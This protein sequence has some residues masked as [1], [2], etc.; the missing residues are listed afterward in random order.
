MAE[1]T[2]AELGATVLVV[3]V[4]AGAED[5]M[6]EAMAEEEAFADEAAADVEGELAADGVSV[7]P[8]EAQSCWAKEIAATVTCES[9]ASISVEI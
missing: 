5:I 1:T 7:T 2:A 6:D 3:M 9:R 8:A 4:E